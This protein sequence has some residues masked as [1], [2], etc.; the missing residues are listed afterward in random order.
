MN[1]PTDNLEVEVANSIDFMVEKVSVSMNIYMYVHT[2]FGH[3]HKKTLLVT[4]IFFNPW[5]SI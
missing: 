3:L 1:L 4:L 5:N 2:I